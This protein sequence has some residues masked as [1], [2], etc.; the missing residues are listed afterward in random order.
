LSGARKFRVNDET[1]AGAPTTRDQRIAPVCM[2][3]YSDLISLTLNC[4]KCDALGAKLAELR[5]SAKEMLKDSQMVKSLPDQGLNMLS[6]HSLH[7]QGK[8]EVAYT[9]SLM[10]DEVCLSLNY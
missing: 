7:S 6:N 8:A 5:S 10:T 4:R 2:H 9:N 3:L 1:A